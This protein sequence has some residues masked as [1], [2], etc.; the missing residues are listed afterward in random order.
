MGDGSVKLAVLKE[1]QDEEVAVGSDAQQ[2]GRQVEK[3]L[4]VFEFY[5]ISFVQ[6]WYIYCLMSETALTKPDE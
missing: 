3:L 6:S 5:F 4:T 1:M 2:V